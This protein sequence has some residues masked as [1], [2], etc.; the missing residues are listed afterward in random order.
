[1]PREPHIQALRPRTAPARPATAGSAWHRSPDGQRARRSR[2][3]V[4]PFARDPVTRLLAGTARTLH[5]RDLA[6]PTPSRVA[7]PTSVAR[8]PNLRVEVTRGALGEDV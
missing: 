6:S 7:S 4:T 8:T 1:M 5:A 2:S 3:M